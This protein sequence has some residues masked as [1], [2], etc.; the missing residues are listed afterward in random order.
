ME[1]NR[2]INVSLLISVTCHFLLVFSAMPLKL[3]NTDDTN[4][5]LEVNY[6]KFKT[7]PF[8]QQEIRRPSATKARKV[9][10]ARKKAKP[11]PK[12]EAATKIQQVKIKKT[13]AEK[14]TVSA[15]TLSNE[16]KNEPSYLNYFHSVREKIKTVARRNCPGYF[17]NSEVFLSFVVLSN[18]RVKDVAVIRDRSTSGNRL[19]NIAIKA[20]RTA[21]PFPDFPEDINLPE[22]N[23]QLVISFQNQ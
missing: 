19:K 4:K 9:S 20:V 3:L 11:L 7:V 23:F 22:L 14:V 6:Y 17:R 2:S 13:P 8:K 18:G 1:L 12:R 5:T 10:P 16:L 15:Q 21:S